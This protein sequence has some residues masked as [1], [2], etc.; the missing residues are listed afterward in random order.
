MGLTA[1]CP[2]SGAGD[3]WLSLP[4]RPRHLNLYDRPSGKQ[5]PC[6]PISRR[7]DPGAV[8]GRDLLDVSPAWEVE[9]RLAP[10][11]PTPRNFTENAS[12]GQ[13][14]AAGW[15]FH[16]QHLVQDSGCDRCLF[17]IYGMDE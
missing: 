10:R 8:K 17:S 7:L 3:S 5:V 16:P 1:V 12:L 11:L 4:T 14:I 6:S 13:D 2:P 15:T 9:S